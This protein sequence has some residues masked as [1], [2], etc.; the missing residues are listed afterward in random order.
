MDL[1]RGSQAAV[2]RVVE[3]LI[4]AN[5]GVH[6]GNLIAQAMEKVGKEGVI[7]VKEGRTFSPRNCKRL[8]R[9]G[10]DARLIL[11][12]YVATI[13]CLRILNPPGVLAS[14]SSRLLI[15]FG[16]T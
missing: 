3:F 9:P 11:Q 7:T 13:K 14:S 10:A 2:G 4:S 15:L 12:K 1:R 8:L 6:V 16:A 5:G